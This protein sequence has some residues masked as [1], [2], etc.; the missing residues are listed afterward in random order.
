MHAFNYDFLKK[1]FNDFKLLFTYTDILC[2]ENPYKTFM[3][4]GNILI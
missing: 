3:S 1:I 2:N 4:I